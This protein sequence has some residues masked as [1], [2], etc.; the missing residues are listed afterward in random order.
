MSRGDSSEMPQAVLDVSDS[1]AENDDAG[2]RH[3]PDL[4]DGSDAAARSLGASVICSHDQE[5]PN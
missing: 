3:N 2:K 1:S 4:P 5:L